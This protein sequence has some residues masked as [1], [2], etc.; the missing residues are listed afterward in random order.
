MLAKQTAAS[1]P[2][3]KGFCH[4]FNKGKHLLVEFCCLERKTLRI[5]QA[6]L[7]CV[8]YPMLEISWLKQPI[9]I[10]QPD[11]NILLAMMRGPH[12]TPINP[13]SNNNLGVWVSQESCVGS[14]LAAD[15]RWQGPEPL[16]DR[17]QSISRADMLAPQ[18][19]NRDPICLTIVKSDGLSPWQC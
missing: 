5:F 13:T 15:G 6:D 3:W 7:Y 8:P 4:H 14:R 9:S 16:W 12:P 1:W 18:S 10:L 2:F 11:L 17:V 19:C